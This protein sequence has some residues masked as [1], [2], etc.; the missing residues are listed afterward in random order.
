MDTVSDM[1]TTLTD[2]GMATITMVKV[3]TASMG[4]VLRIVKVIITINK[5]CLSK[6]KNMITEVRFF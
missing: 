3:I 1:E 4:T 5:V 2:I 6:F